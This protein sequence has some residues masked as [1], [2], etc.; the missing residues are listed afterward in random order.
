M[1]DAFVSRH[2]GLLLQELTTFGASAGDVLDVSVNVNP[3]GPC[4]ELRDAVQSAAIDRYPDPEAA[5]ARRALSAWLGL[6]SEA[7]VAGNGAVDVL[8]AT[9]RALVKRGEGVLV[10]EP[11]FSE[12]R[13]AA[14]RAGAVVTEQ[15]ARPED[16]FAFDAVEF[17]R[18]LSA[19]PRV[20]HVA[21]PSNPAG[22]TV[23][24]ANLASLAGLHPATLFVFDVSFVTLSDPTES[25]ARL[26]EFLLP[27]VVW[28]MSL[29]KELSIPG[30]RAGFAA[31]TPALAA[32]IQA[33][34]PPWSVSAPAGAAIEAATRPSVRRFVDA[35]RR[36]LAADRRRLAGGLAALGLHVHAGEAP[37]VLV[38]LAGRAVSATELRRRLL[39]NHRVLVR[40]A[41]SF[42]LPEHVRIAAR[43][44][45]DDERVLHALGTELR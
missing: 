21:A 4:A 11:A 38:H 34:F 27:N 13:R 29:T 18:A 26:R 7:F 36:A 30:I 22:R 41:T 33:E 16:D 12:F 35:S 19:A 39:A 31:T 14:E 43:P 24:F 5:P 40:D 44:A 1:N 10:A 25:L 17:R 8:W 37:Y 23:G 28:V 3:Y 9:A 6:P 45:R 15:R 2:G 42:G 20:A 32:K